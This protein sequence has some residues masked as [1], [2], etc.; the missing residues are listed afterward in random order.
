MRQKLI[1]VVYAAILFA[2]IGSLNFI[3][4]DDKQYSSLAEAFLAGKLDLISMPG[5]NWAD[6]APFNGHHYSALGPFPAVLIIPLVWAGIFHQGIFSFFG[7]LAVFLLCF[8]LARSFEYSADEA[9]WFGLAFC[10]GTSF[11]GVAALA[12]S[13]HLA[14][15]V[16]II[17]LFLAIREYEEK[18]RPLL[19]GSYIGLSMATR[20]ATGLNIVFFVLILC[21]RVDTF[22]NKVVN[23]IKLLLPFGAMGLILA[24]YNFARFGNPAE[25]GYGLQLNGFGIPYSTWDVPGN[26]AGSTVSLSNVPNHLWIFLAGLP[27]FRGIGTSIFLV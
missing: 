27:S 25:S 7:S 14:H 16:S 3:T 2:F 20:F 10:F 18:S 21:F 4:A 9:C 11:V 6:T 8:R 12:T 1:P 13:N 23:L 19:I 17:L 24:A 5:A 26:T 15:V 22:R